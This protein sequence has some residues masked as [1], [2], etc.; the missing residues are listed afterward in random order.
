M[1]LDSHPGWAYEI[2]LYFD[3]IILSQNV[4]HWNSDIRIIPRY[5][6]LPDK[7]LKQVYSK[8]HLM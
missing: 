7:F 4:I 1:L 8:V 2:K 5:G 6:N 3:S